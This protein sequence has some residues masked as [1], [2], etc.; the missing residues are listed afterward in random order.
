M[1]KDLKSALGKSLKEE[2]KAVEKRFAHADLVFSQEAIKESAITDSEVK[3][4]EV[5]IDKVIRDS[6]T[7]PYDDYQLIELIKDRA[8]KA[9]VSVNKSEVV[10]AGLLVLQSMSEK[11]L[12][13]ALNS[14]TKIKSGRRSI[15][16]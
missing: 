15:R 9:S 6:F 7:L 3:G 16:K 14:I 11:D 5:K 12:L 10:R 8:L 1:K 2:T 13:I 4:D